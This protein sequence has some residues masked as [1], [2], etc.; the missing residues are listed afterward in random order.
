MFRVYP[1]FI[2]EICMSDIQPT[3]QLPRF[4]DELSEWIIEA[5][6]LMPIK[7]AVDAF[8][9]VHEYFLDVKYGTP[10]E[11]R[12]VVFK[13]FKKCKYDKISPRYN[14][15]RDRKEIL[16]KGLLSYFPVANP[17]NRLANIQGDYYKA[18]DVS[19]RIRLRAEV[20]KEV[21]ILEGT[22]GLAT[23]QK[24]SWGGDKAEFPDTD[25]G[26]GLGNKEIQEKLAEGKT[27]DA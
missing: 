5:L 4:V 22:D 11:I 7:V 25:T 6:A 21:S 10:A 12:E 24:V 27:E 26:V 3:E 18:E 17:L 23:A 8:L 14:R 13:R 2:G 15:I 1:F 9:E 19:E 20:R 16:E